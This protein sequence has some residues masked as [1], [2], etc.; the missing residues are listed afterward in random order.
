[1]KNILSKQDILTLVKGKPP[2]I[3]NYVKLEEQVQSNGFDL[4]LLEVSSIRSPGTIG[5]TNADRV[6]SGLEPYL[7]DSSGYFQSG[8]RLLRYYI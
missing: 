8:R 3:S 1:M 2:L 7:V 6:I 4:T 5:I